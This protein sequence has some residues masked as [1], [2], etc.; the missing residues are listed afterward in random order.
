MEF[1]K[2]AGRRF[3]EFQ[4]YGLFSH[5]CR[6]LEFHLYDIFDQFS[7]LL[8]SKNSQYFQNFRFVYFQE[9]FLFLKWT[10]FWNSNSRDYLFSIPISGIPKI[11]ELHVYQYLAIR[12]KCEIV[13][14][15]MKIPIFV[16]RFDFPH[17]LC[18]A[19]IHKNICY[20]VFSIEFDEKLG[21]KQKRKSINTIH[22]DKSQFLVEL[23][24]LEN[25][26][27]L[28]NAKSSTKDLCSLTII[29]K[30]TFR[31][32]QES[33]YSYQPSQLNCCRLTF[34]TIF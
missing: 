32:F 23:S 22:Q 31:Q 7:N 11:W 26:Q 15:Y 4:K 3:L 29:L 1:Q 13:P 34:Q 25:L 10:D 12:V 20:K 16:I 33:S 8:N 19:L 6:F 2:Y 30:G 21:Q 28:G 24:Q 17:Q 5:R 27:P 18:S 14:W 9:Y